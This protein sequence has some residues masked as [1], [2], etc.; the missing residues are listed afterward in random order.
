M[1][2]TQDST[3]RKSIDY[4]SIDSQPEGLSVKVSTMR[5]PALLLTF[6]I[7]SVV[8]LWLFQAGTFDWLFPQRDYVFAPYSGEHS[9]AIRTYVISFYISF[10]IYA[11]GKISARI[12]FAADLVLRFLAICALLDLTNSAFLSLL[13]IPYPLTLV[14]IFAGL[15]GFALFSLMLVERGAMPE[16]K[17][18]RTG[19]QEN[20]RMFLRFL[21]IATIAGFISGFIGSLNS[22]VIDG[23]RELTL[24][25]GIGPG[26]FLFLPMLFLLLYIV[27][28]I[29][30]AISAAKDFSAPVSVI[31]P[32]FNEEHIIGETIRHIDEAARHLSEPV[33][34]LVM[35]NGSQDS[36]A[37]VAQDAIDAAQAVDGRVIHVATPGKAFALNRAVEE[38]KHELIL[39]IDADTQINP[40]S[41]DLAIQNFHDPHIG[42]VGGVPLPPGGG[43]FDRARLVEV[44]LKHGYYAPALSA[45]WGL[46]GVPG[47]FALYRAEALHQAGPFAT[48]MNGEDTDMSFRISELGYHAI[49]DQR[50]KYVSEVPATVA[51]M[52]EQRMRWFRSVYHVTARAKNT[53]VNRSLSV[54]AKLVLP[55]M[56]LNSARRAMMV[57]ILIFG[58]FQLLTDTGTDNV[59]VWQSII[60]VL[61]GAPALVAFFAIII[62]REWIALLGMP[63]YF[64]FRALRA[65]YTLESVLSI[66]IRG[67][68]SPITQKSTI[69]RPGTVQ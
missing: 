28:V 4:R 8:Q 52:R 32:A 66:R 13:G 48:G 6:G 7:L 33:E 17:H 55:Y 64:A 44:L 25:G 67:S 12:K 37:K 20:L 36:T 26:V 31:V 68:A 53:L 41:I 22:P 27:G 30:R 43:L 39:R 40:D 29:E 61:V 14:Q 49:V 19:E 50:V 21:A 69:E 47:M 16:P 58:L 35:D 59:L 63:E 1:N 42:V 38:A 10:S 5:A 62:N 2:P 57:P 23:M 65:W 46:I 45:F 11:S 24:L 9:I 51:H 34:L 3:I 56:L 54:R 18:V 15:I 60:A